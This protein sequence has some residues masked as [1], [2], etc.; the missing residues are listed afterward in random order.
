MIVSYVF[1]MVFNSA[2]QLGFKVTNESLKLFNLFF[3]I[4]ENGVVKENEK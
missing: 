1:L 2:L 4:F 3:F